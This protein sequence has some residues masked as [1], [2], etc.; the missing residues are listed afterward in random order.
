MAIATKLDT[1]MSGWAPVTDH[2][3]VPDGYLAVTVAQFFTATGTAV[4]RC[5]EEGIAETLTPVA[6]F[7]DGTTA[8]AALAALGYNVV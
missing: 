3:E 7:P 1:D 5:T 6:E 4:F 8:E 2:Y